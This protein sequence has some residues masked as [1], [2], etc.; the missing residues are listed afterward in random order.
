MGFGSEVE[1]NLAMKL[2]ILREGDAE[3]S[4]GDEES[5]GEEEEVKGMLLGKIRA[6]DRDIVETVALFLKAIRV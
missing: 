6:R 2:V 1:K 3:E 5:V 4:R